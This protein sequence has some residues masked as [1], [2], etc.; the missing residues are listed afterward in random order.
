MLLDR[1]LCSTPTVSLVGGEWDRGKP[2]K[3]L[4]R[5]CVAW[6]GVDCLK[7]Q[8]FLSEN[9]ESA[10]GLVGVRSV[11]VSRGLFRWSGGEIPAMMR[12]GMCDKMIKV[13][14]LAEKLRVWCCKMVVGTRGVVIEW[15]DCL[16]V[17][18]GVF[19]FV[20][21]KR[22]IKRFR[23]TKLKTPGRTSRQSSH[24]IT[25]PRVPTTIL[26]HHTL[27]FSASL[28][29][30]IILSH[31]PVRI[32]AGISPPD[33]L[34]S[35]RETETL[36]TPTRPEADSR[37]SLRNVWLFRQSTP[38]Q[39]TQSLNKAFPGL[40]LSHSPPTNDTVG[41]EHKSLSNNIL[42]IFRVVI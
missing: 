40:P 13:T 29:T 16:L 3:A 20:P 8:T 15:L 34:K 17:R 10:S 28:V 12:T 11:S 6:E 31:I 33:H 19:N 4:L 25:T 2:G 7:S 38:S 18:P 1:D 32:I 23:G 21:R 35:P 14:K 39:A 41:V 30:L 26:Q 24:S 37:F 9:R 27:S 22:F 42:A 5:D 36:R